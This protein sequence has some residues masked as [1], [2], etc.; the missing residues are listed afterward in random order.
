MKTADTAF[1]EAGTRKMG[2]C[3]ATSAIAERAE[4]KVAGHGVQMC[5]DV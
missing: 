1:G 5:A 3:S 4:D 2:P